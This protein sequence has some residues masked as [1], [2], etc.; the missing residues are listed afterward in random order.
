MTE[1]E[2]RVRDA[3]AAVDWPDTDLSGPVVARIEARERPERGQRWMR[4]ALAV[5][6]IA[7]LVL[8]TPAGRQAVADLLEVAGIRVQWGDSEPTGGGELELGVEVTVDEAENR[9]P[10]HPLVVVNPVLGAPDAVYLSQTP[11]G[12]AIHMVWEAEDRLP[13][14]GGTGI[15]LLYSQFQIEG[16]TG[17]VKSIRPEVEAREVTIRG[18]PGFWIEGKPHVISYEGEGG[19]Q[20]EP[21][22]LAAN[23]LAWDEGGVTHRIETTRDLEFALELAESL[24]LLSGGS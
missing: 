23:V 17:F 10:F 9:V 1:L 14:A 16:E 20:E 7:L 2:R 18:N 12:G 22:R 13:A 8:A 19:L 3:G 5:A 4:A 11:P 15:G 24:Q 21:A 6:A